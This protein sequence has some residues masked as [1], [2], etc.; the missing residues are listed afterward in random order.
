MVVRSSSC[1]FGGAVIASMVF[2][3]GVMVGKRAEARDRAEFTA[4]AGDPLA[5][6]DKLE[7]P[8]YSVAGA[9]LAGKEPRADVEPIV[10]EHAEKV[11]SAEAKAKPV[12]PIKPLPPVAGAVGETKPETPAPQPK[13]ATAVFT[14]Q[15]SS[16]QNKN[17]ADAMAAKMRSAGYRPRVVKADVD[18]AIWY[19]VRIGEYGTFEEGVEAKKTFEQDQQIIAYVTRFK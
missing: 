9:L 2:V 10:A 12:K 18:G 14:L 19:R 5:A 8:D 11:A 1:S 13:K 4:H 6:L 3:L 17:E 7:P 15:L 16:F